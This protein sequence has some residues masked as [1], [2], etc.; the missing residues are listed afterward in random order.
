VLFCHSFRSFAQHLPEFARPVK[1]QPT[2]APDFDKNTFAGQ[3]TISVQV[4]KPMSEI[5]LN[6]GSRDDNKFS[7]GPRR[8][9]AVQF[10][11]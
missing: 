9:S 2:F 5:V 4:L 1:Y 7:Q 6:A 10:P 8:R 11:N 3:E